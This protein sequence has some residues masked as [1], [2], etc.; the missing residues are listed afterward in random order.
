MLQVV[1]WGE[2][3]PP[4]STNRP[5]FIN[6]PLNSQAYNN[7]KMNDNFTFVGKSASSPI[8]FNFPAS[9][10]LQNSSLKHNCIPTS[11]RGQMFDTPGERGKRLL[12]SLLMRMP[13]FDTNHLDMA[14]QPDRYGDCN[15]TGTLKEELESG[16]GLD[17]LT[18][19]PNWR[20]CMYRSRMGNGKSL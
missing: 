4:V 15:V 7:F 3:I 10:H 19:F 18:G 9:L 6:G 11:L 5:D 17:P 20:Q 16:Q 13:G 12:W 14:K 1:T 2:E 8:C